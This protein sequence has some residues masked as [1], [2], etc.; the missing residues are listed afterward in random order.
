MLA[1][2]QRHRERHKRPRSPSPNLEPDLASPIDV[3]LKRRRRDEL[4]FSSPIGAN[5]VSPF[6]LSPNGHGHGHHNEVDYF[7]FP[8]SRHVTEDGNDG[9]INQD[10]VQA[11]SSVSA[12]RRSM[13]GVERRRTK[14]WEKQNAPQ[15]APVPQ[16]QSQPT[17][18]PT[19]FL[20]PNTRGAYSQ[21][22]PMSSSPIRNLPP[23]SS[24]FRDKRDKSWHEDGGDQGGMG[25][26]TEME[27][28]EMGDEEM[29]RE[30]GEEYAVQN[31]LL[32]NLHLAR[33][34]AQPHPHLSRPPPA[35]H[36]S[37]S[38]GIPHT[39]SHTH[40]YSH[41]H[42]HSPATIPTT[43]QGTSS[44]QTLISTPPVPSPHPHTRSAGYLQSP[45][46]LHAHTNSYRQQTTSYPDS[47]PFQSQLMGSS[48]FSL[49]SPSVRSAMEGEG[50]DE[51]MEYLAQDDTLS[52]YG[53][54]GEDEVKRRYEE[55][56]RLLGEL[57]VV[58][59]R[60]WGEGS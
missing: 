44:Q 57:E 50:E 7:N 27:T 48:N 58:R 41:L 12:M 56:N 20:T 23:S 33:M 26:G 55:A 46:H 32:H 60:R 28:D 19:H 11:E 31:S 1:P 49:H 5:D 14:Q 34:Q 36:P 53:Y 16:H 15:L 13:A 40:P 45:S 4:S 25:T 10:G 9:M 37:Q 51:E 18:P 3:I 54:D 42:P 6:T 22:N 35:P 21:P 2:P 24:P 39:P 29:K 43:S 30:W 47:S 38:H 17:P 52:G 59:R 8:Q